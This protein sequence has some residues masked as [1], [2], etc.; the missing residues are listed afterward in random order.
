M[1]RIINDTL[2]RYLLDRHLN[3][4]EQ[5]QCKDFLLENFMDLEIYLT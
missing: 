5:H 1:E 2:L 3:S 4:K